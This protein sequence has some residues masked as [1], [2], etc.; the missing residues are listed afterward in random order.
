MRSILM[1]SRNRVPY[2][3]ACVATLVLA[4]GSE[5]SAEGA[6]T[7]ESVPPTAVIVQPADGATLSGPDLSIEMAVQGISLAR[8]GVDSANTG[9]LHLFINRDLTPEGQAIPVGDGIVHF[10]LAQS[11]H[12]FEGLEPGEYVVIAVLGDY[13]HVRIPGSRTDTVR[14]TVQ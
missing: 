7:Q 14:I 6:Q 2:A 5:Q 8:A 13:M 3:V 10:G 11:E 4:C 9:H 12:V 1:V